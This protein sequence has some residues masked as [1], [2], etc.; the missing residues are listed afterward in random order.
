VHVT[1][2]R[3]RDFRNYGRLDAEFAPGFHLLV[4]DNAQGKT[5]VLEA[6][7][8]VATLRSFRGAASQQMV[9][10]GQ[11]GYFVGAKVQSHA[12]NEIRMY[13]SSHERQLSLNG[14]PVKR[15]SEYLGTLR[16]VVFCTE[17]LQIIKGSGR[18][19]RRFMDLLL[20]Q[21]HSAYL[22]TLQRYAR[23]LRSR[24]ALLKRS[25]QDAA[26]VDGFTA[27]VAKAGKEIM[28]MR[29]DLLPKFGPVAAEAYRRVAQ[30]AEELTLAYEPSVAG[31]FDVALART[32]DRERSARM[33]LVGPHRDDLQLLI[34]GRSAAEFGSEGQKRTVAIALKMAQAE[35]VTNIHG[36]APVL[37]IDDVM[38]ELDVHRR[39]GLIPLLERT[40]RAQGQVFMTA[41]EENW[42]AE[43]GR[44]LTRWEVRGGAVKKRD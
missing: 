9:R 1:H 2:L 3:L 11:K 7:Y 19:R 13:W 12:A 36:F 14:Q 28:R 22:P 40:H 37:L 5:N 6:I 20:T 15:L 18:N 35:Y 4:G 44:S 39:S 24:N 10:H 26:A 25:F 16:T 27:E 23:A 29:A 30:G 33:T 31:D 43:L 8:L 32:R 41:T 38:G 21:T 42:P 34:N 17:D